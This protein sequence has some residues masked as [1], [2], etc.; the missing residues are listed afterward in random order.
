MIS[1]FF[2]NTNS[3]RN[4]IPNG[5]RILKLHGVQICFH[6]TFLFFVAVVL[7]FEVAGNT[8][9]VHIAW[10]VIFL[11]LVFGSIVLHELG[12]AV[13]ATRFR[14]TTYSITLLPIGGLAN[15]ERL[16]A[17][18][19]QECL[20]SLAGPLVNGIIALALYPFIDWQLLKYDVYAASISCPQL[21][22]TFFAI[23]AALAVFNFIPAF[24]MDGGRILRA[25]LAY[26]FNYA[27]ATTIAAGLGKFIAAS[28]IILGLLGG[29]LFLPLLGIFI[30]F[31][32]R[33][34]EYY[35]RLRKMVQ[36]IRLKDVLMYDYSVVKARSR[37]KDLVDTL[38]N[39]HSNYFVVIDGGKPI[40]SLSRANIVKA[41]SA[42]RYEEEAMSLMGK[43]KDCLDG[44]KEL[45]AVLDKLSCDASRVFPVLEQG[46]FVGGVNFNHVIEYLLIHRRQEKEEKLF[47]SLTALQY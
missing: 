22:L 4:S 47:K 12:H 40:G 33:T 41:L 17:D 28:F 36:G 21:L 37:V 30:I 44:E 14:I 16:P 46:K 9:P 31:S 7:I 39:N 35:L 6:W 26:F 3:V 42:M 13:A 10:N 18:T 20:I 43:D 24:P 32:A 23:N 27:T 1:S 15:L 34:E 2:D 29:N 38:E 11:V 5:F 8:S 25:L 19:K 45:G